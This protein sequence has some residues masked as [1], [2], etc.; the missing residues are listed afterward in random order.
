MSEFSSDINKLALKNFYQ[1]PKEEYFKRRSS[2]NKKLWDEQYKWDILPALNQ[3]LSGFNKIT[4]EN[5]SETIQ[6]TSIA[7]E[8]SEMAYEVVEDAKN[9]KF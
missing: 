2:G 8:V 9:K 4:K 3:K 5:E 7:A 6:I 1:T